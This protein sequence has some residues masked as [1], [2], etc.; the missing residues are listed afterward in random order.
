MSFLL[1]NYYQIDFFETKEESEEVWTIW[2][3]TKKKEHI[4]F[5]LY[6]FLGR[7]VKNVE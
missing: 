6:F 3:S 2:F 5:F 7:V 1:M 4:L